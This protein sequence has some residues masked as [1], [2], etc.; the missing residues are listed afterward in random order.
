MAINRKTFS[1][2]RN[3]AKS[4]GPRS[5]A[6]KKRSSLNAVSHGLS[7][8]P[9]VDDAARNSIANLTKLLVQGS[10]DDP[11]L[12]RLAGEAA[13]AQVMLERLRLLRIRAWENATNAP[14]I[15]NHEKNP[16]IGLGMDQVSEEISDLSTRDMR[17]VMSNL[18]ALPFL[19]RLEND[20]AVVDLAT[21]ELSRYIRYERQAANRRDHALREIE[22]RR[23]QNYW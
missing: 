10:E 9:F 12:N 23:K 15:A 19:S 18:E 6:G 8:Q 11:V 2:R 17:V 1:N 16:K 21:K 4:T 3:A 20:I 13:E 22:G 7:G 5:I 14:S